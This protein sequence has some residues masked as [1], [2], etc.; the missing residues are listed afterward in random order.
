MKERIEA[1]LFTI[2]DA[3]KGGKT[4]NGIGKLLKDL[5]YRNKFFRLDEVRVFLEEKL[6]CY[7]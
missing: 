5:K 7:E 3:V 4:P 1:M 2:K 6:K